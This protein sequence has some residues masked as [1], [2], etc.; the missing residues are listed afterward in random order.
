MNQNYFDNNRGSVNNKDIKRVIANKEKLYNKTDNEDDESFSQGVKMLF[1]MLKDYVCG[2]YTA[3]PWRVV[4][5]VGFTL[6]YVLSPIDL[7]PDFIPVVGLLDD[8][9]CVALCLKALDC[10]IEIYKLW[11]NKGS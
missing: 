3:L 5:T 10:E 9:G 11:R 4:S 2:N 6:L 1:C 8:I 7:I